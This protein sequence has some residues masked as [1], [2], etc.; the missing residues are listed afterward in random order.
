M[1]VPAQ[2]TS[3]D[4]QRKNKTRKHQAVLAIDYGTWKQLIDAFEIRE[5]MIPHRDDEQPTQMGERGWYT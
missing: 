3:L 4:D 2:A 1:T 5:S